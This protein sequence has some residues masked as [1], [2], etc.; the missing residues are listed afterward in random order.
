MKRGATGAAVK[1]LQELL[2]ANG[3]DLVVDGQFGPKT[4][5]AV[6]TYQEQKGLSVDGV[7]GTD[8]MGALNGT[9]GTGESNNPDASGGSDLILAGDAKLYFNSDTGE[10]WVVYEVPDVEG[11]EPLRFGWVVETDADLEAILGPGKVANP[12]FTG[13][14]ADFTGMGV[15]PLGGVSELRPF[16]NIEV[17]PFDTWVEDLAVLAEVK[18]WLL[19]EDYIKIAV[20][21]AMERVDG[22]ISLEEV[23]GTKWWKENNPAQRAW[24]ETAHGDPAAADQLISDNRD[25]MRFKLAQAGMDNATDEIINFLAD[26][27]TMGTWSSS[28]LESQIAI[29]VDPFS[30]EIMDE[31]LADFLTGTEWTPDGTRTEEGTVRELVAEWLGP[32]FGDWDEQAIAAAAGELRNNPDGELEL[33]ESLKDQRMAMMPN[34]TNR[35]TSY[36][37]AAQPWN[38]WLTSQWGNPSIDDKDTVFQDI[39]SMNDIN[40]AGKLARRV[41]FE[42]GYDK[43][44]SDTANGLRGAMN[45]G[46]V[47]AV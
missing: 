38:T 25:A 3:A 32:I 34:Y 5:A 31:G 20:Q 10:H 41:G 11:G 4:E 28:K 12:H 44:V 33:I 13:T 45:Q 19:D 27:T 16:E 37:A 40:E 7:A 18:P 1:E 30:V 43:V 2:N 23:Q 29:L 47:G 15:V 39:I 24:M 21:A 35:N 22:S 36:A 14:D 6:R 8:T 42:R 26:R 46:T 9:E 17:D